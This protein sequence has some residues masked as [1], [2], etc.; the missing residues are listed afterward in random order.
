MSAEQDVEFPPVDV[1]ELYDDVL[2]DEVSKGKGKER[3]GA[4]EA[5]IDL[6]IKRSMTREQRAGLGNAQY[7]AVVVRVPDEGWVEPILSGLC[8]FV[9]D[10]VV[11]IA[12]PTIPRNRDDF[13]S[14]MA[15]ALTQGRTVIGVSPHPDRAL[16]NALI[17][18][19][20]LR[21]EV[22][23]ADVKMVTNCIKLCQ[24]GRMPAIAANLRTELL[25][26][27][28]LTALIPRGGTPAKSAQRIRAAVSVKGTNTASP[29][30]VL[31]KLEEAIEYGEARRWALDLRDDL[32]D[33][34]AGKLDID[35][36]DKGAIFWGPPGTGKTL[37]ARMLG[38]ACGIPTIVGSVGEMFA[39]S[40][41][42]LEAMI[43][44][45]RK[46]FDEAKAR[47]PAILYLD[48]I[49]AYPRIDRLEGS[50]NSDYWKPLILDFYTLLD[51]AMSD[52]SGVI[53]VGSTN[54][55]LD[56]HPAILRPGRMERSIYIG[57]PDALGVERIMRHHLGGDLDGADLSILAQLD[58]NAGATGA[59]IEEQIR[60][61][62]RLARRGG[63]PLTLDDVEAQIV[64][65]DDRPPHQ[66]RRVALH[67]AGHVLVGHLVGGRTLV[68]VGIIQQGDNSGA[69][70]YRE[71]PGDGPT[72]SDIEAS[73][74]AILGGRAAEEVALGSASIGSG[75]T[76]DSDLSRATSRVA[77]M[78]G[79]YG[80]GTSLIYRA[81][82]DDATRQMTF[83]PSFRSKVEEELA[84]LYQRTSALVRNNLSA[85]TALTEALLDKRI[86]TADEV[87]S[88]LAPFA[89]TMEPLLTQADSA[90]T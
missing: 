67:E 47:A 29:G 65:K 54:S 50:R 18:I 89:L 5:L 23:P 3:P 40:S 53:V 80:L 90:M 8:Q 39:S 25:S 68:S 17:N 45:Q 28:E 70:R 85:L 87:E 27:D 1:E 10:R 73:I 77:G 51:G 64:A 20:D 22:V 69:V 31:P 75:G 33:Y 88:V 61:A 19:A 78:L 21:L 7:K 44:A 83:D 79:S 9:H 82:S 48:E 63:R 52:R 15:Q 71:P 26:F 32:M 36:V 86:M 62:R 57:P 12:R 11:R 2:E 6:A 4:R 43:K 56:I 84:G 49:N 59:V 76:D 24:A 81:S 34:K 55:I 37:L 60:A 41:G 16:P 38:E 13:T 72:R 35:L 30:K 66:V 74:M 58:E 46:L 42:Y 14:T